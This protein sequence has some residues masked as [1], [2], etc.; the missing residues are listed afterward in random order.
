MHI[1]QIPTPSHE[2]CPSRRGGGVSTMEGSICRQKVDAC[3]HPLPWNLTIR[4]TNLKMKHTIIFAWAN[5]TLV[6]LSLYFIC[7]YKCSFDR[8]PLLYRMCYI[9]ILGHVG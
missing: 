2:F 9:L 7:I 6:F 4:P 1:A 3:H 5:I 8:P